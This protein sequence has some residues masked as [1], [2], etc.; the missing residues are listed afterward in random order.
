MKPYASPSMQGSQN[1]CSSRTHSNW[2][3]AQDD[4][5]Q[6]RISNPHRAKTL[7]FFW[8]SS[9]KDVTVTTSVEADT[10]SEDI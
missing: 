5:V 2:K 1:Q 10:N 7:G 8:Q 6:K 4:S 9:H 3:K